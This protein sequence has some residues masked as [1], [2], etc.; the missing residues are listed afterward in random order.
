MRLSKISYAMILIS[1]LVL[2]LDMITTFYNLKLPQLRETNLNY[3]YQS[4]TIFIVCWGITIG[5]INHYRPIIA[6]VLA[7]VV[8]I[9]ITYYCVINNLYWYFVTI[10]I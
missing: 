10:S 3:S 6:L 2:C 4:A 7:T 5:A 9:P 8:I 1:F